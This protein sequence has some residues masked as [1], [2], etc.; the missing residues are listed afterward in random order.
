MPL[1]ALAALAQAAANPAGERRSSDRPLHAPPAVRHGAA[2]PREVQGQQGPGELAGQAD[3]LVVPPRKV[4]PILAAP[5]P[6][7]IFKI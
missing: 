4:P 2:A 6:G 7:A 3:G 1:A 5:A